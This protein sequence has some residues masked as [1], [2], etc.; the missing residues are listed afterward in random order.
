MAYSNV[1]DANAMSWNSVKYSTLPLYSINASFGF[2]TAAE[3]FF[4]VVSELMSS[5]SVLV[6]LDRVRYRFTGVLLVCCLFSSVLFNVFPFSL[7]S[8]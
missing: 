6:M 2:G 1:S 5:V 4:I 7:S 8:N 3:H